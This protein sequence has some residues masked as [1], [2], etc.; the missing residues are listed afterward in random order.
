MRPVV[1]RDNFN[2]SVKSCPKTV[3]VFEFRDFDCSTRCVY[4][5]SGIVTFL[6]N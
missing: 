4:S 6:E 1:E 3:P 5:D 2:I